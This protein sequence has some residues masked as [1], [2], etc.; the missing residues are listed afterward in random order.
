MLI[1][2]SRV[3]VPCG[4]HTKSV[5]YMVYPA[6]RWRKMCASSMFAVGVGTTVDKLYGEAFVSTGY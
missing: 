6:S 3:M 5:P 1:R 4:P 2:Q